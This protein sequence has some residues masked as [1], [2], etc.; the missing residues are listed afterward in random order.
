MSS[1]SIGRLRKRF[2]NL[3]R[4]RNWLRQQL[5]PQPLLARSRRIGIEQLEIRALLAT[6]TVTSLDDNPVVD[7]LVTLREAIQA[8]NTDL[9]VDGSTA[10]EIGADT[11]EFAPTLTQN[12]S[13]T[14]TLGGTRL[15]ISSDM[16][17]AGPGEG[18]LTIS[19]NNASQIFFVS[20]ATTTATI[21]GMTLTQGSGINGGAI[22]IEGANLTVTD[23][24]ITGNTASG[25]GGGLH[26]NGTLTVTDSTI[27]GNMADVNGGGLLNIGV[28]MVSLSTISFNTA[29]GDGGGLHNNGELTVTDSTISG[30]EA[31]NGGGLSNDN[32]MLTVTGSTISE[33]TALGGGG[34]G[35]FH[36]SGGTMDVTA[37]RI[38]GNTAEFFGGG[39]LNGSSGTMTVSSS[40]IMG[41]TSNFY[42]GGL[43]NNVATLTVSNST[44]SGNTAGRAGGGLGSDSTLKITNSTIVGNRSDVDGIDIGK[45]G[46]GGIFSQGTATVTNSTISDNTASFG[47]G[48]IHISGTPI[49]T[50]TI[51][52]G[53]LLTTGDA[54]DANGA[55][56]ASSSYNLI[57]VDSNL[58]GISNG[59]NGNQI[60]TLAMPID[61]NFGPLSF[62]G[63]STQ[64]RALLPGSPAIDAGKNLSVPLATNDQRSA[65]FVRTFDDISVTN[66]NGGD[67]TDIGAFELQTLDLSFFVV[68]TLTDELDY[69]NTDV[70]LREA[71]NSASGNPGA[72][73]VTFDQ[74]LTSGGPGTLTMLLGEFLIGDALT[75]SGPGANLLT[76]DADAKSRIFHINDNNPSS[77]VA[78]A[79]SGLT[80]T[81]GSVGSGE[82]GGAIR[83]SVASLQV[84]HST[85]WG[86]TASGEGGGIYNNN[87]GRVTVNFSTISGNTADINGGGLSSHQATLMVTNSTISGNTT[88]GDGGGVYNRGTSFYFATATVTNSTISGNTAGSGG[89]IH[90]SNDD[91]TAIITNT[92]VAGNLQTL[93]DASDV[94]G[95]IDASS[96]YN[97]I[98]VDSG[99]TGISNGTN[100]N[101]LGTLAAPIDANL[102]PLALNGGSTQTHALLPGS[103]AID[104]GKNLSVPLATNDQRGAPF[105][106]TFD[107]ISV[108][109]V[110]GGD[111]TDIGAFELQTLDPLFFNVSVI[112]G[113]LIIEDVDD[114][115]NDNLTIVV[116]G[117]NY[118]VSDPDHELR[119][120]PGTSLATNGDVLIPIATV[121][122]EITVNSGG[123]NDTLTIDISGGLIPEP[124]TFD[125][126]DGF[127]QLNI[128][129]NAAANAVTLT[130]TTVAVDGSTVMFNDLEA[131]GIQTLGGDDTLT[132]D[133]AGGPIT[134]PINYDGGDNSDL[135]QV[136]GDPV[137]TVTYTVG[138]QVQEGKITH[139]DDADPSN[140]VLLSID[141]EN[142]EPF[143]DNVVAANLVVNGTNADN[144]ISYG[145]GPGGGIFVGA[146]GLVSVDSFE[147]IEFNNKATLV[148]NGLGGSDNFSVNAATAAEALTGITVNGGDPTAGSDTAIISG[149]TGDDTINFAPTSDDDAVVTGAGPVVVITLATVENA[150]IDG[151]GGDDFLTYNSPAGPDIIELTM[152]PG[153]GGSGGSIAAVKLV[154]EV[155]MPLAFT[156][157]FGP[158]S[159][160]SFADVST[161]RTDS[162][163]VSGTANDDAFVLTADGQITASDSRGFPVLPVIATPGASG[164]TVQGHIGDDAF[165]VPGDH[166]FGILVLEGGN[167]DSGSDVLN[168]VGS[169]VGAIT[170][171]LTAQNP[172]TQSITEA[173]FNGVYFSGQ[174]T[175]NIA[176]NSTLTVEGTASDDVF[177]VTPTAT[178]NN[179]AAFDHNGSPTV[180]FQYTDATTATFNGGSGVDELNIFGDAVVDVISS[181]ASSLTVDGSTVGL[182]T[183]LE[184][185]QVDGLGG[186]D[187]INLGALV[188]AGLITI[189]GGDGNDTLIGSGQDDITFAG[190]GN[191]I[192]IG[193]GGNDF[194]YGEAGND[195]FGNLTLTADNTADDPGADFN[196]GGE[197]VDHFVWEPGD[198]AD[199][200]SGGDDGG[201]VLRLFG[202]TTA[203]AFVLQQAVD[204]THF[205]GLFNGLVIENSGIEGVRLDP[206]SGNDTIGIDDLF[207][208]EVVNVTIVAADGD[209][210][211]SVEGRNTADEI[212]IGQ[213]G[214]SV[215]VQG[216]TYNV[217]INSATAADRLIVSGNAGDDSIKAEPGVETTIGIQLDGDAG[218]D[219]LS[220]D[221]VINGGAG[222][223]TLIGGVGNDTINGNDGDD[224]IDGRGGTNTVDG[225][226]GADT[227][228]VSGTA[229][230]E[231]LSVIHTAAAV[232][233]AGGISAG[234]NN[235]TT[236]ERVA[237][238][239]GAG[240]DTINITTLAGGFL[241]Y[242][243]LGGNPIGAVGDTLNLNSPT[244]VVFVAGPE[245]DSGAFTDA[246]GAIISFDEI[247]ALGGTSVN[248]PPV[249]VDDLLLTVIEDSLGN[250]LNLLA[251]DTD[252][253]GDTLT[254]ATVTQPA[255]GLVVNNGTDVSYTPNP[256]F[257]GI[258]TFSYTANDGT[259]D[260]NLATV[261]VTVTPVNDSPVAVPDQF[262][263]PANSVSYLLTPLTNDT[264]VDGDLLTI[265]NVG[266][267]SFGGTV[268]ISSGGATLLYTPMTTFV[269]TETFDYT[270]EDGNGTLATAT[271][272]V[273]V[274]DTALIDLSLNK[275]VDNSSPNLGENVTFTVTVVNAGPGD[276]TGV[277]VEDQ[278]PAEL[279]F[280][281]ANGSQGT[282]ISSSGQW[283]VNT[284]G[285]GE[286]ATLKIVATINSA[287]P[288]LNTA[289]VIDAN[290]TDID[291]TPGNNNPNE[292]DQAAVTINIAS[293]D[294]SLTKTVNDATPNVGETVSFTLMVSNSGPD[295]ATNLQ[296]RDQLPA[297][298]TF[299]SDQASA[300][301]YNSGTGIWNVSSLPVGST[302]TLTIQATVTAAT[303]ISNTAEIIAV[304]QFDPDSTPNN[305]LLGEDD[306]AI[307]QI[308]GQQIDLE[309][310][311]TVDNLTPNV[312]QQVNFTVV[313]LNNG[314]SAATGVEV[315]DLLP[316]GATLVSST[317][318][319][320]S[321]NSSSGVW[322]VGSL[323]SNG[324]ATLQI[325]ANV[326]QPGLVT[327]TAQVIAADQPDADSTPN[328]NAPTEDDQ[329]STTITVSA[330]AGVT[331]NPTSGLITSEAGGAATFTVVLDSQPVAD[332]VI[333]LSSSDTTEGI[334]APA[335]LAF[336]FNDWN[337]PQTVTVTGVDDAVADGDIPYS[338]MT[339]AAVSGD[340][341]YNGLNVANVSVTN[342]DNDSGVT[343]SKRDFLTTTSTG[344]P[345]VG[346]AVFSATVSEDGATNLAYTFTRTGDLSG[347]LAVNFYVG[348]TAS[349]GIDYILTGAS[350]V[351]GPSFEGRGGDFDGGGFGGGGSFGDAT[352]TVMFAPGSSL[353]T[354]TIN[355]TADLTVEADETVI[356]I[357]DSGIGYI[358]GSSTAT[359]MI[360]NDDAATITI[361]DTSLAEDAGTIIFTATLSNPVD[362]DLT[363]DFATADGTAMVA[364]SD[365]IP[366]SNS[367]TFTAGGSLTILIGVPITLDEK[368]EADETL[369]VDLS[370]LQAAG[371]AVSIADAQGLGT[372]TNDDSA[373][374]TLTAVNA[375]R[376]EG[377]GGTVTGFT[378]GVELDKP[379]Q[380]GL[381]VQ[382]TTGDGT[383]TTADNDYV[384]NSGVLNFSGVGTAAQIITVQVNHD[385][386]AEP[387][388]LFQVSIA[389]SG[390]AAGIDPASIL[391]LGT[392]VSGTILNDDAATEVSVRF[393]FTDANSNPVSQLVVGE[394]SVLNVY[395]QDIRA[396]PTSFAHAYLD[397]MYNDVIA[398]SGATVTPGPDFSVSP[399][400]DLSTAGL[401]DEAGGIDTDSIRQDPPGAEVLLFSVPIA[402]N[403]AGTLQ[404]NGDLADGQFR[405]VLFFNT[406]TPVPLA[407][408]QFVGGTIEVV[409]P[410]LPV[411]TS[412]SLQNGEMP[413]DVNSDGV[414]S[415]LDALVVINELSRRAKVDGET[416]TAVAKAYFPDVNG[417]HKVTAVDALQVI[418]YLARGSRGSAKAEG[419]S[420]AGVATA[421]ARELP[422]RTADSAFAELG[423]ESVD[424]VVSAV[425]SASDTASDRIGLVTDH[426]D[427]GQDDN[428]LFALL[429]LDSLDQRNA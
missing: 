157:L 119:P 200:N 162:L 34:G 203:D 178:G 390:F 186:D 246:D 4:R 299:V 414:V 258:D 331:V 425:A 170:L 415:A 100:G 61:A 139:D 127:D 171:N 320:G 404:L 272:T 82:F 254:I 35:G 114:S 400:G 130:A 12:G 370:N 385:I 233:V 337:V 412:I 88:G 189:R 183:G 175:I 131:L 212:E 84:T 163:S 225:G 192:L 190:A 52:A 202:G 226:N 219:L 268:L 71:I 374:L 355:P 325:A 264:D 213:A 306:L 145:N 38:S 111:G 89:G 76:I 96:S 363:V 5:Q 106:R 155:L 311:K 25:N 65:P 99:L 209:D 53:N 80:L 29:D 176:A 261:T 112:E 349:F 346:I 380:G 304:D 348:G 167:P 181:A 270:V 3:A 204:P 63:G 215:I 297:G 10:G 60:G 334:V 110:S 40:T 21:S 384:A 133:T 300:G 138:P 125:G 427:D 135:L 263:V 302:A 144:A 43:Y 164:L 426:D 301:T 353:A 350:T 211:V 273:I 136:I 332:V 205:N 90:N 393:E 24:T 132:V 287:G 314:P 249:A 56:D 323:A 201:D 77:D 120:G 208:T 45:E 382:Y 417:D 92:I 19:G 377:T 91:G 372:I 197:G 276:A 39:L 102:G 295:T 180:G 284:L 250:L 401:I 279:T 123:G 14:I 37:S 368:V 108:T 364:D 94:S 293:A 253:D 362:T 292:D 199:V 322:S 64:T 7:G 227:I 168:F 351:N 327:N 399:Q 156:N 307:A 234:T 160:L 383:A 217:T 277:L 207:A 169:G 409:D 229:A 146:T 148:L 408:I 266:T 95:A 149:T 137:D 366:A 339:G 154:G 67:G 122:G 206:L 87:G 243:I 193:G 333:T 126:G 50:N 116:E 109:N 365:Y 281:T 98:G 255:N 342:T 235:I 238:E 105:V 262:P 142:L 407:N 410:P 222:N 360:I 188:F 257:F 340:S 54:S 41:N 247:E 241:D 184:S 141:F 191:D 296:I 310:T 271:V 267:P 265:T 231:T 31:Q 298:T 196:F 214:T 9:S 97:L 2:A 290:E 221:A 237:V 42:G 140:G 244:G 319:Q 134:L 345:T 27:S 423:A 73:T 376:N 389:I 177:D 15:E 55:F 194:Q 387:D 242:D 283:D 121:T 386:V 224:I 248:D 16:T 103:P 23:S 394:T 398:V 354:V 402:A 32:G 252:P 282:Y 30:N 260:S 309:L 316:L 361:N 66:A 328:N 104:A 259:M 198:G 79:I 69:T 303:S 251:N 33:N 22:E 18:L 28:A 220:A 46:G 291:S 17:I 336:T 397:I 6:I 172:T 317:P 173:G 152:G 20:D 236:V 72:D 51:V 416:G 185:L 305:G 421:D 49:I 313:I 275:V 256:D 357:V 57:G 274:T 159:Y 424:K 210:I 47:G 418:N 143:Q 338:I 312:G 420:I 153:N 85:I 129:G 294:L 245:P 101:Q 1:R 115:R 359:G 356:M 158:A 330:L 391:I 230:S 429:A 113:V 405:N 269:G 195:I 151:Q 392:P 118:R 347:S 44:I 48:G 352:G 240:S 388:E 75:I 83:N 165:T 378:F 174:E 422:S 369:F 280:I 396:N 36:N 288:I 166:P 335:S 326:G 70:S 26:N 367:L 375:N 223:D 107:D 128:L 161:A 413:P 11:I 228:L 124:I 147:T 93:G 411:I 74:A 406:V 278:L 341:N 62:N 324:S 218:D 344:T 395:V 371:R 318:S 239:A 343:I 117:T 329:D 321:Y 150:V 403:S 179:S 285:Q 216:L 232:T 358:V 373:T 182:G 78:V 59:A 379:I 187:N 81:G 8:A 289:E 428:E 68:T 58:T 308:Q 13:E 86:N 419:E 381:S 286:A 315:L